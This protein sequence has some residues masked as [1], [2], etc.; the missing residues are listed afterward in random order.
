MV[1]EPSSLTEKALICGGSCP[2]MRGRTIGGSTIR[3]A[4][5]G[6]TA[7]VSRILSMA[8]HQLFPASR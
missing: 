6:K 8:H 7:E 4:P 2:G 1:I 3:G 5:D